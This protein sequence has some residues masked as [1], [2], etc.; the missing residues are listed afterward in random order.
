MPQFI[1]EVIEAQEMKE[2]GQNYRT[3]KWIWSELR[4]QIQATTYYTSI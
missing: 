2:L 4:E 3:S 1:D